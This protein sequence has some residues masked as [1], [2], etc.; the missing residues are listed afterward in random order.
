M[1]QNITATDAVRN[2]SEL[3]NNIR[4]RGDKYTI[5]KGGKPAAT[6]GPVT[7]SAKEKKLSELKDIM[8]TL[9][10]LNDDVSDFAKNIEQVIAEQPP[11][12]DGNPW[13]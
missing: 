8:R 12:E 1:N 7:G 3:L 4:Y 10:Q 5:L 9:P 11:V 6:I 2:F 13:A